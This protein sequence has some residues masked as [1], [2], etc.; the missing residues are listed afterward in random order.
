[1]RL[2]D[3]FSHF[4]HFYLLLPLTFV[5]KA[6]EWNTGQGKGVFCAGTEGAFVLFHLKKSE[7]E[8]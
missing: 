7:K 6:A 3:A 5:L 2:E 1:M 8:T 4:L